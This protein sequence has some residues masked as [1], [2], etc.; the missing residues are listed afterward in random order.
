MF[1]RWLRLTVSLL[2]FGLLVVGLFVFV[3]LFRSLPDRGGRLTFP[4]LAGISAIQR[5]RDGAV[6]IS[7]NSRRDAAKLLGFAHAQDRFFQM[8][9]LRR[10]GAG[11][12]AELFG[13][14]ALPADRTHRRHRLRAVARAAVERL[15]EP[16]REIIEDYTLGVNAGLAELATAPFEYALLRTRPARWQAEDSLLVLAAMALATQRTDG[17]PELSRAVVRDLFAPA[18][19]EFLLSA[20]DDFDAALDGSQLSAPA[21][22]AAPE[23]LTAELPARPAAQ[24]PNPEAA[25]APAPEQAG[26]DDFASRFF[27]A[28]SA[29][30]RHGPDE[31]PGGNAVA[32]HGMRGVRPLALLANTINLPLAVPN[33]WYRTEMVWRTDPRHI[34]NLDGIT[35]PGLPLLVA[36]SNGA[37]AWGFTAAAADTADLVVLETDPANL[38]RY[39]TP[40]GWRELETCTET[41]AVRA[42]APETF[43]FD[44][45]IWGPVVGADHRGRPVALR[46]AMAEASA[47][48]LQL[49][50]LESVNSARAAL[51]FA[52]KSGMPQ[53]NLIVAD[54]DG[55]IGWSVTGPLPRRVGFDGATPTS[56]ADGTARWD[57]PL[58][59][60]QY[61]LIYNP[62]S[63]R[64]WSA[65]NRM[66]GGADL[67]LLG[68]GG[69]QLG[70]RARQIRHRLAALKELSPA[71]LLELQ[72]DVRGLYLER[73]QQLLLATLDASATTAHPARA[74][75]RQLAENWGGQ[76]V[77]DSAG[78]R[79]VRDFRAAVLREADRLV[80]DRCRAAQP[81]FDSATLPLDR[82]VFSLASQ[83]PAGW[84]PDG[85]TGWR[86][87]LLTAADSTIVAAGGP[88]KLAQHT[89]GKTNHLAM[90]HPLSRT[91]PGLGL[92]LD[93]ASAPLP[94][95]PLV[96][97]AQS[98]TFGASVRLVV[99][100]GW[101]AGS[102]IQLPGGQ[103]AN[104]LSPYYSDGHAAWLRD[105]PSPLQPG[106][107]DSHMVLNPPKDD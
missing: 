57:G 34:R 18:T 104:P 89:L 45:T 1:P 64:I 98:A 70:A 25:P 77:P 30:L 40:D 12:L 63:G 96:V 22:P 81:A 65:D 95:D 46:W 79:L 29:P 36:G 78:Y 88:G 41:I 15:P 13:P 14:A 86:T 74:E 42:A 67:A 44:S 16:Q 21:L 82:I 97:R 38:R 102:L 73:W 80:F 68:N 53:L 66:V 105:E 20:A 32:I 17:A 37:L 50:A 7:A 55:N 5:D 87:L 61:P 4:G 101:E 54:S 76:A 47:Y 26:N 69:H 75:L 59:I 90:R 94:G 19:A 99:Q 28:W 51:A 71:A 56:W 10:I 60:D 48:D 107:V 62:P 24:P 8:D 43:T 33:L 100:P 85:A 27:A 91:L 31:A 2:A 58:P 83:Q 93:M 3:P 6:R 103:S 35:L 23:F 92:F 106:K 39:R 49:S 9:C 52:K 11:E 84:H 72:F